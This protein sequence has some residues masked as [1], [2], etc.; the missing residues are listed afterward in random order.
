MTDPDKN[1]LRDP[2]DC[3][4]LDKRDESAMQEV[5][6]SEFK[7]HLGEYLNSSQSEPILVQRS[8]KPIAVLMSPAEFEWL[9]QMEDLY[10]IA[11]AQASEAAGE[12]IGH[13]ESVKT[14]TQQM[15]QKT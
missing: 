2:F 3:A 15:Q 11:R 1:Q 9:Q 10:W 4:I 12:W 13:E 6:S 14:L 5:S 7:N 8:G